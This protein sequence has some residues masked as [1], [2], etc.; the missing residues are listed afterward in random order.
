MVSDVGVHAQLF[1]CNFTL[2]SQYSRC[3]GLFFVS[4]GVE[5]PLFSATF[6]ALPEAAQ[7]LEHPREVF[8]DV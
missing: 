3:D 4:S 5:G 2:T 1:A 6:T 8:E 7:D